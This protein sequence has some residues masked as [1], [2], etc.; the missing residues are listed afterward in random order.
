MY[1]S[2]ALLFDDVSH[3]A[4]AFDHFETLLSLCVLVFC[5]PHYSDSTTANC[6][7]LQL[8]CTQYCTVL[9]SS[10]KQLEVRAALHC[11]VGSTAQHTELYSCRV[12]LYY[13]SYLIGPR[14]RQHFF[15]STIRIVSQSRHPQP[16]RSRWRT[17]T[18]TPGT[19]RAVLS[20]S[21]LSTRATHST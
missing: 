11:R 8:C 12:Q 10:A 6:I 17:R 16:S 14:C 9:W 3:S 18:R 21:C 5:T 20:R 15:Q 19:A 13:C 7:V 2:I 1:V 4:C